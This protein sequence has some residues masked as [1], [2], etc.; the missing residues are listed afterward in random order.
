[1][2]HTLIWLVAAVAVVMMTLV[3][4]SQ[5]TKLTHVLKKN[6]ILIKTGRWRWWW[7]Y[8][9]CDKYCGRASFNFLSN[10]NIIKSIG[11]SPVGWPCRIAAF[12]FY[13]AFSIFFSPLQFYTRFCFVFSILKRVKSSGIFPCNRFLDTWVCSD[14]NDNSS[15][16]NSVGNH[17]DDGDMMTMMM[18]ML[19][20]IF[21]YSGF[22]FSLVLF[23]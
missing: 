4:S 2:L 3:N 22:R 12:D 19:L 5:Y 10:T 6:G 18:M 7:C 21:P 16:C 9:W 17:D 13:V 14:G 11:V 15:I 1:M 8:F 20:Q 23:S